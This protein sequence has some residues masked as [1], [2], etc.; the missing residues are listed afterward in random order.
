MEI[1]LPFFT[2]FAERFDMLFQ[3]LSRKYRIEMHP[4]TV[5]SRDFQLFVLKDVDQLLDQLAAAAPD[6]IA[7]KDERLP[8]WAEIWPSS[9][10][11][12]RF[13]LENASSLKNMVTLEIGCG[14]GL[15]GIAAAAAGALVTISDYQE[16]ALRIAELNWLL[17]VGA[18][19]PAA[20]MDWRKPDLKKR[21][22]VILASDVAYEK[23]FFWP[24]VETF[25]TLLL[26]GGHVY[27]SEPNRSIARRF[28]SLLQ[29]EGFSFHKKSI[30]VNFR[31]KE[32][33]I[34]VYDIHYAT[35]Q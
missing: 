21:F 7:L 35:N 30:P 6:D 1:K 31:G 28:F 29:E 33:A 13:L 25:R 32:V 16:D 22:R 5:G 8:Y 34:S 10:A 11:L 23:R 2:E 12:S 17:N 4:I 3:W 18:S 24:L 15:S 20:L 27:L 9:L 14:L 19:P 26:P